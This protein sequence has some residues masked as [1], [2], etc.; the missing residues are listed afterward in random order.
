MATETKTLPLHGWAMA[1]GAVDLT[2][3]EVTEDERS[4]EQ[5][6]MLE[7]LVNQLYNGWSHKQVGRR[8]SAY[9]MPR[10]A[11]SGMS[12]AV[13]VGS[14]IALAP[15][16]LDSNSDIEEMR[17]ALPPAWASERETLSRSWR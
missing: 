15:R 7:G 1:T 17:K 2:T 12:Y 6:E 3:N 16:R 11:D 8:A 10:L 5:I 13:F 14:L 4:T 9:Y